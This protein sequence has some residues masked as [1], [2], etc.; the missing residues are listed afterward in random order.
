MTSLWDRVEQGMREA[1][2]NQSELCRRAHLRP[3]TVSN[4]KSGKTLQPRK[5]DMESVGRVINRNAGWLLTGEGPMRFEGVAETLN[6]YRQDAIDP[7][8]LGLVLSVLDPW[9][10]A[11]PKP[12]PPKVYGTLILTLCEAIMRE[13][14]MQHDL[15]N[16]IQPFLRLVLAGAG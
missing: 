14:E 9:H 1:G 12:L 5:N 15:P 8:M 2:I 4:W 16:R 3:N 7:E 6:S 11:Q 10:R 13:P